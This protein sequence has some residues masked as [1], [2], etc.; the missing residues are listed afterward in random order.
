MRKNCWRSSIARI[1]KESSLLK[2]VTHWKP[3]KMKAKNIYI[4]HTHTLVTATT[5]QRLK[6]IVHCYF[7]DFQCLEINK[8]GIAASENLAKVRKIKKV[9]GKL[10]A[11]WSRIAGL[12]MYYRQRQENQKR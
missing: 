5:M 4:E 8:R 9:V 11:G 7:T 2:L 6:S 10:E 3:A 1:G 12:H